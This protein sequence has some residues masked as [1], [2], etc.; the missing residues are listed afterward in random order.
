MAILSVSRR[1]DIPAFYS[2]W[3][4]NRLEADSLMVRNPYNQQISEIPLSKEVIDCIVFWTKNLIPM[5]N[6]MDKLYG[7]PYYFQFTL[8]G[9]DKDIESNLPSKNRLIEAFKELYYRGNGNLIWRYD[10]IVFTPKYTPEWH[11]KTFERIAKQ[12]RDY[13]NKCVISFVDMP[14]HVRKSMQDIPIKGIATREQLMIFCKSLSAIA[15]ENDMT[16]ATCAEVVDL[17]KCGI[18]HNRCIDP[19]YITK[20]IGVPLNVGKD[21]G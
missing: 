2:D 5:L 12:L 21:K 4:F 1:T 20:I 11:L 17:Q 10:P 13:T 14:H 16:V 8:T 15:A 19:D 3:F 18:E 7:Y 9:Y 6:K